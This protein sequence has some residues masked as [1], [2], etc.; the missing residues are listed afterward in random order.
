MNGGERNFKKLSSLCSFKTTHDC[1]SGYDECQSTAQ[2]TWK[3]S[4]VRHFVSVFLF[5]GF[6]LLFF[7]LFFFLAESTQKGVG[8]V[9]FHQICVIFMRTSS[10]NIRNQL[11]LFFLL[12]I[13]LFE[14]FVR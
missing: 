2:R 13:F 8:G 14:S 10:L 3:V 11:L 6:V 1:I 5:M 4:Q 9:V 7:F 12:G